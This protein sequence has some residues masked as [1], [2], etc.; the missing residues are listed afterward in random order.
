MRTAIAAIISFHDD[1]RYQVAI[2]QRW[3][4]PADADWEV[5]IY[6]REEGKSGLLNCA[7][8]AHAIEMLSSNFLATESEYDISTNDEP[9]F[10]PSFKIW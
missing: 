1:G 9:H 10:R 8:L 2:K 6:V 4:N 3:P 5:H 7:L